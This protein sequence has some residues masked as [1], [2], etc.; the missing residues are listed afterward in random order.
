MKALKTFAFATLMLAAGVAKAG[1]LTPV[2]VDGNSLSNPTTMTM[3]PVGRILIGQQAGPVKV[4]KNGAMLPN[5]ALSITVDGP[6]ATY[7][8][9][10]LLGITT[11]PNFATNGF[12]Y[13]FY[14]TKVNGTH[15]KVSRFK[16][17][18]DVIDPA[19]ETLVVDLDPVDQVFHNGGALHFDLAGKLLIGTGENTVRA[20]SQSL[21][22]THGKILRLN[23][24]GSIPAD[25]PFANDD[26]ANHP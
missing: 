9:R 12:V 10:G 13:I 11:D 22:T 5:N 1:P 14:T 26:N 3:V 21:T 20:Y 19:S 25:N 18:G 8:E 6:G 17:T 15:N 23:T 16:M 7:T 2:L 24:D 4:F